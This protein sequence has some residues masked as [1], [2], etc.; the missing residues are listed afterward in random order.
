MGC[1]VGHHCSFFLHVH[2]IFAPVTQYH[3]HKLVHLYCSV[4][5]ELQKFILI[6]NLTE[7]IE[8]LPAL[9]R[10]TFY[11]LGDMLNLSD[12]HNYAFEMV[13]FGN[14]P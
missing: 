8:F 11:F 5:L 7:L 12:S 1:G 3:N 6:F 13:F 10:T 4:G 2:S 9:D 14:K